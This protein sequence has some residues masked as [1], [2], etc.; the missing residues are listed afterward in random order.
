MGLLN[1]SNKKQDENEMLTPEVETAQPQVQG[2]E[3]D[4]QNENEDEKKRIITI[5][6]GTGMPIDVIYNYI[7]K[8]MEEKGY[9]DALV[10]TDIA[11]RDAEETIIRNEL[12]LLIERIILCYRKNIREITVQI[13][14]AKKAL[15]L[16]AAANL[17]AFRETYDEHLIEINQMKMQLAANDPKMTTMI[18]S[19]RRGFMKGITAVTMNFIQEHK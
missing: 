1:W 16:T 9:E 5:K 12:E 14:N 19:Y 3:S 2:E 13:E 10:N 4:S 17:E 6:W 15:A 7:H 18:D 8:D 11:Y